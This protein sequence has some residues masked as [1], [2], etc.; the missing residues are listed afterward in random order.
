MSAPTQLTSGSTER[1]R[2]TE[3][4]APQPRSSTRRGARGDRVVVRQHRPAVVRGDAVAE[5]FAE[6]VAEHGRSLALGARREETGGPDRNRGQC[7]T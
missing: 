3:S 2:S 5:Q 6:V 1:N 4:P 7:R